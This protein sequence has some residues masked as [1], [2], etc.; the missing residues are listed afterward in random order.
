M[1]IAAPSYSGFAE[2][3][4]RKRP[5]TTVALGASVLLHCLLIALVLVL[6]SLGARVGRR[7]EP[8]HQA[9]SLRAVSAQQWQQM[10]ALRTDS[11]AR[12]V[13]V[14]KAAAEKKEAMPRGQVVDV[15]EGNREAAKDAKYLAESANTV[16]KQT[17]ARETSQFYTHAAPRTTVAAQKPAQ[18]E[19]VRPAQT[20]GNRGVGADD[21][22]LQRAAAK[23][24]AAERAKAPRRKNLLAMRTDD[25]K[26]PGVT[27]AN[28][29][30]PPS[31]FGRSDVEKPQAPPL[32][33]SASEQ[34]SSEGR[35]GADSESHA[36]SPAVVGNNA[37][38]APNEHL[39][40]VEEGDATFLNTREFRY[41][42]FFNRVKQC[43]TAH[44]EPAQ[45]FARHNIGATAE[46]RYTVLSV[47]LSS[48]GTVKE[49]QV[50]RSS[51]EEALDA[52]AVAAF[53][54]SQPF[55]N[56]PRGLVGSDDAIR[57]NFG[58]YLENTGA[59]MLRPFR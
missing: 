32:E 51:G 6:S 22:P 28:L 50:A 24:E 44:W 1:E 59:S 29:L 2:R 37:G 33:A 23:A 42:S 27:T 56:P 58:F 12:P 31:L 48:E 8:E 46:G 19:K 11:S 25:S 39:E 47:T 18:T 3:P 38:A 49:I 9:V 54:R 4:L 13:A 41:A 15:A 17:R 40:G 7:R 14:A 52:E 36:A 16:K 35:A 55:P 34:Q 45:V 57:F 26:A 30:K 43:V 10:R 5:T 21:V 20:Q 53:E